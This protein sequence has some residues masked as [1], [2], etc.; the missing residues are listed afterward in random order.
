MA[1]D[2]LYCG[3]QYT[4]TTSFCPDCGRLTERGFKIR[5]VQEAEF[6]RLHREMKEKDDLIQH[7]VLVLIQRFREGKFESVTP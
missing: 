1:K 2:C 6:D 7:L 4:D 3:L 5:L